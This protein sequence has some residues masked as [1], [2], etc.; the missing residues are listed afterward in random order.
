MASGR[1][2]SAG[3]FRVDLQG[4]RLSA[5]QR[6]SVTAAI[7]SA[8]LAEIAKLDL[9][10]GVSVHRIRKEWLGIWIGPL[11]RGARPGGFGR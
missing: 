4:V 8:A 6:K 10:T 3:S 7:E 1:K 2:S 11:A 5:A 9:G